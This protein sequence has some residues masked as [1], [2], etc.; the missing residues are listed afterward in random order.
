MLVTFYLF[1]QSV[2]LVLLVLHDWVHLPPLTDIRAMEKMGSFRGRLINSGLFFLC[3]AFPLS[4]SWYYA[5]HFPQWAL[6]T[7]VF[8]YS[9]LSAGAII[10]WWVPYFFGGYSKEYKRGFDEYKLT[11]RFLPTISDH[12]VPNTAHVIIHICIWICWLLSL[13]FLVS[14]N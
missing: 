4:L 13:F 8:I 10:A 1:L 3:V 2:L 12:I 11:H 9:V 7:I 6:F 14:S 5:P